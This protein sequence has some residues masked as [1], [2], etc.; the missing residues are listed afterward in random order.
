MADVVRYPVVVLDIN[1]IKPYWRNP[2][3]VTEDAVNAVAA[4]ITAFG[5]KQPIVVDDDNTIIIGHTRYAALRRLGVEK[6]P[7]KVAVGLSVTKAKEL[8]VIDN[9]TSE[10][11]SWDFE[12]LATELGELDSELLSAFFPDVSVGGMEPAG[13][14]GPA[15]PEGRSWEDVDPLVPFVCPRC[16]H[17]FELTVTRDDAMSGKL[18]SSGRRT[19]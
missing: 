8:R 16:F 17:S 12:A 4:S 5:Y 7:V 3:R 6:V 2:R 9:R 1:E 10:L 19:A 13:V 14:D 18:R 11:T 15:L